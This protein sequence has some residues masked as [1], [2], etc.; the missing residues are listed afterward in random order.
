MPWRPIGSVNIEPHFLDHDN[1]WKWAIS[2]TA[3]PLYPRGK[4]SRYP[5]VWRS[6]GPLCRSGQDKVKILDLTRSRTSTPRS[7]NLLPI[8][9]TSVDVSE[10]HITL[11]IRYAWHYTEMKQM[12][13]LAILGFLFGLF[14]DPKK[15]RLHVF[16]NVSWFLTK[17]IASHPMEPISY[18]HLRQS[19]ILH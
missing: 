2:F 9:Q 12:M 13:L 3:M 5:L 15:Y 18:S 19:R 10:K 8:H 14:F 6:G 7:S 11:I 4:N 1:N 17:N 16:W